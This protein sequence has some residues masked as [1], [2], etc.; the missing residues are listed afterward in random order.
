MGQ[1]YWIAVL[2]VVTLSLA[3]AHGRT[4][5]V[6][7]GGDDASPATPELPFRTLQKAAEIARAGDTVLVRGG[8]YRGHVFLRFS[9]EPDKPI[10]FKNAPGERPIVDREGKG[11]IELQS[12]QGWRR[13]IGWI[14]VEGRVWRARSTQ[15]GT[16]AS[17]GFERAMKAAFPSPT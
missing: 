11:R 10:V 17:V 16:S 5:H 3:G 8:V 13:P 7:S 2:A 1:R 9:G 14:T 12:E 15:H 4:F 6:G